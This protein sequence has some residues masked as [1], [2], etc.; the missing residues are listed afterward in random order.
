MDPEKAPEKITMK[1]NLA[2]FSCS[3]KTERFIPEMYAT[4][5]FVA[6]VYRRL[7]VFVK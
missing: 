7:H 5:M 3:T 1:A 4:N 6:S 2:K